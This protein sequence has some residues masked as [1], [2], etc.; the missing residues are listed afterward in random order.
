MTDVS[1]LAWV[2]AA[3]MLLLASAAG[4]A[5]AAWWPWSEGARRGGLPLYW[6]L[7]LAPL[8]L[9]LVVVVVMAALPGAAH[10]LHL[11]GVVAVLAIPVA[12]A[13]ARRR[14]S[15]L[16]PPERQPPTWL[17]RGLA[18]L[19]LAVFA[20]LLLNATLLP[21]LQ[22]DALEYTLVGR[23]IFESR[24]L[25]DYPLVHPERGASGFFGPW[26]HP[27]L[28][29]ALIY[30]ANVLQ[31]HADAPG[32]MRLWAPWSLVAAAGV[33][34]ALGATASRRAG[35]AAALL[36]LA[37]PLLFLGADTALIDAL[38]IL[39][40]LLAAGALLGMDGP[41][42]RRGAAAGLALG[43][44]LWTHSQAILFV[45]LLGAVLLVR[46]ARQPWGARLR[47]GAVL[48]GL[49]A[50]LACWPYLR[51]LGIFGSLI[52][53]NPVVFALPNQAWP[54]YFRIGRGVDHWPAI[55]QYGWFK[56]WS[57]L[58]AY[59]FC[60]WIM[61]PALALH[62]WKAAGLPPAGRAAYQACIV[63]VAC[64]L[65]GVVASTAL[66][67]DLMIKNER[68]MLA[69]VPF[70]CLVGAFGLEALRARGRA[71][72][73]VVSTGLVLL[74]CAQ[75]LAFVAYRF[76]GSGDAV[77]APLERKLE[78]MPEYQVVK[79]LREQTPPA[80]LVLSLKPAD[81]YYAQRRMLSYL[82]PRMLP[83]YGAANPEQAL[84]ILQGLGVSYVHV[85]D[86]GLPPL[87]N[88]PLHAILRSPL[89]ATLAFQADGNQVY[90]LAPSGLAEGQ[91][92]DLV[93]GKVLWTRATA[94]VLGGRKA[95]SSVRK[96]AEAADMAQASEGGLPLRLFHRDWT[97]SLTAAGFAS[98]LEGEA[99]ARPLGLP[100]QGGE[101]YGLDLELEGS[102]LVRIWMRQFDAQGPIKD[103]HLRSRPAILLSD[104]TLGGPY[105]ERKFS[106][107]VRMLA[108][109]RYATFTLEHVGSSRLL[110]HAAHLVPLRKSQP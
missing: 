106:R 92:L 76:A 69:I 10:A 73:V 79:F 29:V 94:L 2:L 104:V 87:Y 16:R 38:P 5:I 84:A 46:D 19:L 62:R 24:T 52:S 32:L 17:E 15:F 81:M 96:E 83:F 102:G 60:F 54:D 23:A 100:V 99:R 27:P 105:A 80:A 47:E 107:R 43:L 25:A 97:T 14:W 6:G 30:L 37:T 4:C 53:D 33:T 72:A 7:G 3:A 22:N 39:G 56:G 67:L 61:L 77:A 58:E 109:A 103:T 57:A 110:V 78:A 108:G 64:Y 63:L 8:L 86:Y 98:A 59:G 44:A 50:A 26:T 20:V 42:W 85:P 55:M 68:Y 75:A 35:L 51:N 11:A 71:L 95:L 74:V 18:L 1:T 89:L 82:D 31:G 13:F 91:A 9:G 93:D 48:F 21:L 36:L 41:S 65:L 66:G 70:V 49:A 40:L 101:E 45:P 28:Y 88:S 90:R 34:S 12:L